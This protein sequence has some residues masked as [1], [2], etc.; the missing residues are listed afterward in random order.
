MKTLILGCI[1]GNWGRLNKIIAK[2]SPEVVLQTGD[3]GWWPAFEAKKRTLYHIKQEW[4]LEGVK[5][6][7]STTL[8]W[9]D[10]NHED[11]DNLQ[12]RLPDYPQ[13][14]INLYSRVFYVPRGVVVTL[15]NGTNILFMGGAESI[16]RKDRTPGHDWFPEE[17]ISSRDLDRALSHN[18]RIDVVVSHTC[19]WEW[20]PK[21]NAMKLND[22]C[23]HALSRI[24]DRYKPALWFHGHW[25]CEANGKY[26]STRWQCLDYP[27][28]GGRWWMMMDL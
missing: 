26:G 12:H 1:H 14:P 25:H 24:L 11:H 4:L 27:G 8:Y 28:H 2:K 9:C 20:E 15:L 10:G 7:E 23:R 17:M 16:D 22:P 18:C 21:P 6:P 5:L 13:A 3:F 19:P